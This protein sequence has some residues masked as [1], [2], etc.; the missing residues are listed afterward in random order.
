MDPQVRM[1]IIC[2]LFLVYWYA[3]D[4]S[5][6]ISSSSKNSW[7]AWKSQFPKVLK[8]GLKYVFTHQHQL[9]PMPKIKL[10]IDDSLDDYEQF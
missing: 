8:I 2:V 1:M 5:I 7:R 10:Y 6:Y 9:T 4:Q 3:F